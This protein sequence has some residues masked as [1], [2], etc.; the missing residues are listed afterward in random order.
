M[1][2]AL[3]WRFWLETV[4]SKCYNYVVRDHFSAERLDRG[5]LFGVDP[6][7]AMEPLSG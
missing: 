4:R 2:K 7:T 5:R 3:S 6:I 1:A